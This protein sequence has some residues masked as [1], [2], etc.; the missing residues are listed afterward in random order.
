M[1]KPRYYN[2]MHLPIIVF[3]DSLSQISLVEAMLKTK[4]YDPNN[5]TFI[6][7]DV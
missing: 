4:E 7:P 3:G 6:L 1:I 2:T 5:F